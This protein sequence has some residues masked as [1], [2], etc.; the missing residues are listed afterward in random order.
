[1]DIQTRSTRYQSSRGT[2]LSTS[3][4]IFMRHGY[5]DTSMD[6]IAQQSGVSKTTL[7]AH[8]ESKE[9][10]FNQV[11]GKVL[12]E[13]SRVALDGLFDL[14]AAEDGADGSAAREPLARERLTAVACRILERTLDPE[15]VALIRLCV[16][17]GARMPRLTLGGLGEVRQRLVA[18]VAEFFRDQA[19]SLALS[20]DEPQ[21]A[22][23][24]FMALTMR[25][26]MLEAVLPGSEIEIPRAWRHNAGVAA[27]V[28]V[29][30]YG[31]GSTGPTGR[32]A[33]A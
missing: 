12:G 13:R 23:D 6:T 28:I 31:S 1:M 5:L 10:L 3:R 15:A 16:I 30:L 21:E 4:E 20:I 9:A 14:P 22:A 11:V 27:D 32:M 24:L 2:I 25:D 19:D 26:L 33:G 7:Y 17:E 18:A 8:F 29:R